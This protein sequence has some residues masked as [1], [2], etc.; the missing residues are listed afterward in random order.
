MNNERKHNS[1]DIPASHKTDEN[2]RWTQEVYSAIS[3]KDLIQHEEDYCSL[4]CRI[5]QH[6]PAL[7]YPNKLLEKSPD[8]LNYLNQFAIMNNLRLI[9]DRRICKE[10]SAETPCKTKPPVMALGV[11]MLLQQAGLTG[12]KNLQLPIERP[13]QIIDGQQFKKLF[14]LGA[15]VEGAGKIVNLSAN[16]FLLENP[17]S[18]ST[19]TGYASKITKGEE[20]RTFSVFNSP[21]FRALGY[22][23][24]SNFIF[25]VFGGG[26]SI[27][28]PK[29]W[30]PLV[31]MTR[32]TI[33]VRLYRDYERKHKYGLL[34]STYHLD[35]NNSVQL[36]A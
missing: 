17:R 32:E 23:Q 21:Y 1:D 29:I 4:Q 30:G 33:N 35:L 36:A 15:K 22:T 16:R 25:H 7:I 2:T 34:Y 8:L 13:T 3:H 9:Q 28:N 12:K 20:S 19:I 14:A 11:G 31:N 27:D 5:V 10:R 24:R 6:K 18:I 26:G